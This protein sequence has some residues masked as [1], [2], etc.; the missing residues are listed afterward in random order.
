MSEKE[1]ERITEQYTTQSKSFLLIAVR[2]KLNKRMA[3]TTKA[4]FA[5]RL[6]FFVCRFSMMPAVVSAI[7]TFMTNL[8]ASLIAPKWN[9]IE[10][11][12]NG[13]DRRKMLCKWNV[14]EKRRKQHKTTSLIPIKLINQSALVRASWR[15]PKKIWKKSK[16]LRATPRALIEKCHVYFYNPC[17]EQHVS[18]WKQKQRQRRESVYFNVLMLVIC[19]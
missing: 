16:R 14:S 11:N 2:F 18:Q 1:R 3:N 8:I 15:T 4:P 13:T 17:D 19:W 10:Q 9:A 5:I 12:K 6:R 7:S